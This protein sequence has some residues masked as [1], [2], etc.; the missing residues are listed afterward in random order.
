MR[1]LPERNR[2]GGLLLLHDGSRTG[3]VAVSPRDPGRHTGLGSGFGHGRQVATISSKL[4]RFRLG[5]KLCLRIIGELGV[6]S[7]RAGKCVLHA[8]RDRL[9]LVLGHGARM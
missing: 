9:G 1:D 7:F 8:G 6:K 2:P 4:C 5:T 3:C